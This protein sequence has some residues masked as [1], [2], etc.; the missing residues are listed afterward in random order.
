MLGDTTNIRLDLVLTV[1]VAI[2]EVNLHSDPTRS[3][4]WRRLKM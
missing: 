3:L 4:S 1:Y 2:R